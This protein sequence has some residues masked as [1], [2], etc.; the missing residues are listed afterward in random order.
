MSV[1]AVDRTTILIALGIAVL[2]FAAV[3]AVWLIPELQTRR[4]VAQGIQGKELAELQNGART[5]IVQIIGGLA[6]ILTFFATWTQ[7]QD[8]RKAT[9]KTLRLNESQQET[10][11]FTR[12]VQELGSSNFAL[13]LGGI[14]SLERV[15]LTSP[16]ERAPVVQLM[17]AYLRRNHPYVP[18]KAGRTI[19]NPCATTNYRP[20]ADTQ[21]ALEVALRLK[22]NSGNDHLD[23]SNLDLGAAQIRGGDLRGVHLEGSSLAHANAA[24][25]RFDDALLYRAHLQAACFAHASFGG[26]AFDEA[27]VAGAVFVGARGLVL[28]GAIDVKDAVGV[29]AG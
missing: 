19:G 13:R 26:A 25:A 28:R 24:D 11:Q 9:N 21:A 18:H 22:S 6:L 23:L 29:P 12:A 17:V 27:D 2:A 16:E 20:K 1:L 10:D 3:V 4:W 5:T 15:A 14:Y 7:I 8:T